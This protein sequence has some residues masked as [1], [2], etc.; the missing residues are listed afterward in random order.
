MTV[1]SQGHSSIC[2]EGRRAAGTAHLRGVCSSWA[3]HVAWDEASPGG[4]CFSPP[5]SKPIQLIPVTWLLSGPCQVYMPHLYCLWWLLAMKAVS[6]VPRPP[7]EYAQAWNPSWQLKTKPLLAGDGCWMGQLAPQKAFWPSGFPL[8]YSIQSTE[9]IAGC[10]WISFRADAVQTAETGP[11]SVQIYFCS[12][13]WRSF[14]VL[15]VQ[16]IIFSIHE[17]L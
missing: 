17:T 9:F 11:L 1:V 13:I 8:P 7:A 12:E 2:V 6:P 10:G 5:F 15:A 4:A 16:K 14:T 3:S